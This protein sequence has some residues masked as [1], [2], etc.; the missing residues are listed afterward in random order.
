MLDYG[1]GDTSMLSEIDL[2][3]YETLS[4]RTTSH[5]EIVD[6]YCDM[7]FQTGEDYLHLLELVEPTP[8]YE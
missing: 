1:R 6:W 5:E 3:C 7:L 2:E 4:S 8:N